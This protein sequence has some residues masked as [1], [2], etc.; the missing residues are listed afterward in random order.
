MCVFA[1]LAVDTNHFNLTLFIYMNDFRN[2]T[3]DGTIHKSTGTF[4]IKFQQIIQSKRFSKNAFNLFLTCSDSHEEVT[5]FHKI[6][7]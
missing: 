4:K 7:S 5:D 6:N 3:R 1:W 2:W